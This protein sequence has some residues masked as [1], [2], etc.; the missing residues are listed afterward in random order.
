MS[1]N[2][3]NEE[4]HYVVWQGREPGVY[5]SWDDANAQVNG[6]PR[7]SYK[8]YPTF[9]E[10]KEAYNRPSL[11]ESDKG[12]SQSQSQSAESNNKSYGSSGSS[13]T[14]VTTVGSYGSSYQTK[15]PDGTS[16]KT[17]Y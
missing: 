16:K 10:A 8:G 4:K 17:Y 11:W 6:H 7:N 3:N 13:V 9:D 1:K 14:S 2:K 15:A 5:K 12:S